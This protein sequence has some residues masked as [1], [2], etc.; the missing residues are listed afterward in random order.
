MEGVSKTDAAEQTEMDVA[1]LVQCLPSTQ[2]VMGSVPSSIH[3]KYTA[4]YA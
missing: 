3:S 1:Q 2:E 4:A